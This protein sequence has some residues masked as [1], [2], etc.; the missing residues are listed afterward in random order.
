M[1]R[2]LILFEVS[3]Q[4]PTDVLLW[5]PSVALARKILP[6]NF[7]L[8]DA[9][10]NPFRDYA[11]GLVAAPTTLPA[12]SLFDRLLRERQRRGGKEGRRMR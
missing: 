3:K 11:I 1:F 7:P 12:T 5:L 6:F 9:L 10:K 4:F 2:S 8:C